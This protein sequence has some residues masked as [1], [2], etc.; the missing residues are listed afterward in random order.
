MEQVSVGQDCVRVRMELASRPESMMLVRATLSAIAEAGGLRDELADD[1]KTA[2]SEA[3]NNVVV[4]AYPD[5]HGP[6]ILSLAT[7]PLEVL[8][9]VQDHGQGIR[10]LSVSDERMGVGLA[11]ISALADRVELESGVNGHSGTTVRMSFS[12]APED[13]TIARARVRGRARACG[14]PHSRTSTSPVMSSFGCRRLRW[15]RRC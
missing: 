10:R 5:G 7:D 8:A 9:T 15:W 12:R 2:V 3:C 1:L 13:T 6:L 14:H 11:V 4:H